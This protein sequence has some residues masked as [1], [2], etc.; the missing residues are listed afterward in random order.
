MMNQNMISKCFEDPRGT[1]PIFNDD[2]IIKK[3]T[4]KFKNIKNKNLISFKRPLKK[5][6]FLFKNFSKKIIINI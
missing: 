6:L 4:N 3:C 2:S 1:I 5:G